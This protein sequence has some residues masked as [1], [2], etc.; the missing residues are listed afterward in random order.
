[1]SI[2]HMGNK[3]TGRGEKKRSK[4]KQTH[5]TKTKSKMCIDLKKHRTHNR[6]H[7]LIYYR[8]FASRPF[9]RILGGRGRWYGMNI[10]I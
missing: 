5:S 1:M 2:P 9:G 7:S 4:T 8:T 3:L 10:G 6:E